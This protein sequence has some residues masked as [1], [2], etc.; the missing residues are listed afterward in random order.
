MLAGMKRTENDCYVANITVMKPI[1]KGY[2]CQV[3]V[4]YKISA[5]KKR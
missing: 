5:A 4:V 1:K 2:H 3:Y